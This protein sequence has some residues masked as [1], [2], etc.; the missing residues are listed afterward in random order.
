MPNPASGMVNTV[1][2]PVT[3]SYPATVVKV[4]SWLQMPPLRVPRRQKPHDGGYEA[5]VLNHGMWG[6]RREC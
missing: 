3:E 5:D 1:P 4:S 6:W 2:A